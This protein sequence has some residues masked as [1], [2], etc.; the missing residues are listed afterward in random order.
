MF[1]QLWLSLA[2]VD[3]LTSLTLWL[4]TEKRPCGSAFSLPI[5]RVSSSFLLSP[6]WFLSLVPSSSRWAS[7]IW[8]EQVRRVTPPD[9]LGLTRHPTCHPQPI[10]LLRPFILG[11]LLL[12]G[13][14]PP[15]WPLTPLAHQQMLPVVLQRNW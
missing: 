7:R 8:F 12:V 5:T 6:S 3:W 4:S 11:G 2:R 9:P 14:E 10:T 13:I 1:D 15:T